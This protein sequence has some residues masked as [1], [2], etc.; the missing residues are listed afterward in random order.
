MDL[1]TTAIRRLRDRLLSVEPGPEP[2]ADGL[3]EA[4][5]SQKK[6][7]PEETQEASLA[8]LGLPEHPRL[9]VRRELHRWALEYGDRGVTFRYFQ[10]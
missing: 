2:P 10:E 4:E 9:V 7:P 3:L 6:P 8:E 5:A 1:D